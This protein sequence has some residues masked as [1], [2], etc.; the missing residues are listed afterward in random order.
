MDF[1]ISK[2]L[3]ADGADATGDATLLGRAMTP[4]FASPEQ[5]RVGTVTAA[6][7]VYSLG[8]VLYE[9]LTGHRPYLLDGRTPAEIEEIICQ[10]DAEKPSATIGRTEDIRGRDRHPE[11][12][13]RRLAGDLDTIVL[14]AIRKEPE[15]RYADVK[16]F[17]DDLARHLD[18]QP[19]RARGDA[20][21]YRASK[22]ITRHRNRVLEAALMVVVMG[23]IG[24]LAPLARRGDVGVAPTVIDSVAVMPLSNS[25]RNPDLEYLSE[26]L[27]EGLITDLS[28]VTGLK[29]ASRDAAF[30]IK[31]KSDAAAIGR[32]LKVRTVLLGSLSPSTAAVDV[33]LELVDVKNG[34]PVW[35]ET[36]SAPLSDLPGLRG[37][38]SRAVSVRL[39]YSDN[40][41]TAQVRGH[42]DNPEAYQLFL[43][44][45]YLWNKR[46]E[47]G[48]TR[49]IEYFTRALAKDPNYALAYSGLADCYNLLGIWGVLPPHEAMPKV[50]DAAVHALTIDDS[51]A[52]AHTSLAMATWVY[53]WNW[54]AA[55][56][57]FQRALEIDP[58]YATAHDWYAYYL[59]SLGRFDEAIV[60]IRRAQDIDPVSLSINTDVG[61]IYYWAGQYDRAVEQL[62]S[63]IQV[64]PDFAMARNI[65][66]LTYLKIRRF[67]EAVT[68]LE[69]ANRLATGPRTL[70]TLAYGYGLAGEPTKARRA[71]NALLARSTDRYT[72]PF[73]LAVAYAG[74][75]DKDQAL[76][77]LEQA[78]NDRSD[79]MTILRVYPLVDW[80]RG[81]PRFQEL[82]GR[83]G[84]PE[85]KP[86]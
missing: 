1:G 41:R 70:S 11:A 54:D 78:F 30:A 25:T 36:Y 55:A 2:M 26:G 51:L 57:E 13:R 79:T 64:E 48:F 85:L 46:T 4:E 81:E 27:A 7:D 10:Q 42:S 47:E 61:E 15:R 29:V 73:N 18:G 19:V 59:A 80:L 12:L 21:A 22:F 67:K 58:N 20:I 23:A 82:L 6:T 44:G 76:T 37:R 32:T 72:S 77:Q 34:Q 35:R 50:K 65:L 60:H 40:A 8:V 52:E 71:L 17:S 43:Q 63:V 39:G 3:L 31:Q 62:L 84:A 75:R 28:Q 53:D 83:V 38:M 16:E 69:S 45:R 68:E 33:T 66:G 9:L 74:P 86:R 56:A 24:A 14:K 5:V 49:G